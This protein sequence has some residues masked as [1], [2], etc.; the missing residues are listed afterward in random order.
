MA[1]SQF[2]DR[3]T[4]KTIFVL[5]LI[6]AAMGFGVSWIDEFT[7]RDWGWEYRMMAISTAI[8]GGLIIYFLELFEKDVI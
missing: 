8:G 7:I 6:H 2:L 4:E 5:V 1:I 3:H